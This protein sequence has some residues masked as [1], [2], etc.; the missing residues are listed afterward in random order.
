MKS[1]PEYMSLFIKYRMRKTNP[2]LPPDEM[3]TAAELAE[4]VARTPSTNDKEA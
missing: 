2:V 4:Q 3:P 1:N